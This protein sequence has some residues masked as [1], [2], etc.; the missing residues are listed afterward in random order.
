MKYMLRI[1]AMLL[2]FVDDLELPQQMHYFIFM[3]FRF[4]EFD[5]QVSAIRRGLATVVPYQ[6]LSLLTWDE[7]EL[8]VKY[9]K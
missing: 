4:C 6:L 9:S 1:I 8:Q 7:L 5:A 3:Q 2:C